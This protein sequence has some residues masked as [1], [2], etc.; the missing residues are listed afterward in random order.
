MLCAILSSCTGAAEVD[1]TVYSGNRYQQKIIISFPV[2]VVDLAGGTDEIENQL[3]EL[4]TEAKAQGMRL[5]WHQVRTE[6]TNVIQYEI[7]TSMT[8]MTNA[9]TQGFIWREVTI[10]TV[11]PIDLS[12]PILSVQVLDCEFHSHLAY[13]RRFSKATAR[14]LTRTLCDG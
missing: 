11:V 14:R 3:N 4:V 10:L 2:D 1:I 9:D 5:T 13:Q 12:T 8:E 7:R 6:Q